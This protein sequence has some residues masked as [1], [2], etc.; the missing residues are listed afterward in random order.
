MTT[1]N[2]LETP[3][4]PKRHEAS[5]P[6]YFRDF[7]RH[8]RDPVLVL[9]RNPLAAALKTVGGAK[10]IS[11][12]DVLEPYQ[13]QLPLYVGATSPAATSEVPHWHNADQAEAYVILDG[14][15]ELLAK[16]RWEDDGW[17]Q[18]MAYA[19]DLLIVRP[20]VCH[21]FRWRSE[22]GLALV[23]KAPQRAG[24][25]RFPAGKVTCKFC[26]H[27]QRGCVLPAEFKHP[28]AHTGVAHRVQ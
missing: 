1:L 2:V 27:F 25:G 5:V 9:Q 19:G 10:G 23:F 6:G 17:I 18:R 7:A 21:W 16:Y 24:V 26:P 20:E 13:I 11:V 3:A 22:D 14:Q 4:M 28:E 12:P 15:A 8:Q